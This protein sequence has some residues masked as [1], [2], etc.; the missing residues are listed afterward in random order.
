MIQSPEVE[1]LWNVIKDLQEKINKLEDR[2]W[3]LE[4]SD[5]KQIDY[6]GFKGFETFT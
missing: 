5:Q 2:I 3:H 6:K 1:Q 4:N